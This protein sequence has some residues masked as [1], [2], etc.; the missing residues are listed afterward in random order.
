MHS[1]EGI[2]WSEALFMYVIISLARS[3]AD[4]LYVILPPVA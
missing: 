2:G 1:H 3:G 4:A